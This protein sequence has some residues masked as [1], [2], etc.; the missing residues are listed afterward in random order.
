MSILI[1]HA[2]TKVFNKSILKYSYPTMVSRVPSPLYSPVIYSYDIDHNTS[3]ENNNSRN[4][5]WPI[6]TINVPMINYIYIPYF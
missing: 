3:N 4:K 5:H 6:K 1:R 2:N